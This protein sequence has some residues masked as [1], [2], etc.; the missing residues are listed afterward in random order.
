MANDLAVS[1][2]RDATAEM[3]C[4]AGVG[5][6]VGPLVHTAKSGRQIVVIDGC[7]LECA[8]HCLEQHDVSPDLHYEL[9]REGV[10]KEYH[11]E[12]DEKEAVELR[13]RLTEDI[14]ELAEPPSVR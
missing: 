1:L 9:S 10:S 6:D 4:I 8:K 5:G 14:H 12:Y 3:S 13:K 2:D 7:P 11:A